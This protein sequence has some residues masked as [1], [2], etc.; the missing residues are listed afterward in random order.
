[1]LLT[2]TWF[3]SG[4]TSLHLRQLI[5]ATLY[6]LKHPYCMRALLVGM[7]KRLLQLSNGKIDEASWAAQAVQAVWALSGL[8][9]TRQGM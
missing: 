6:N 1:M 4:I 7:A 5:A 8:K 3:F 9:S 2:L